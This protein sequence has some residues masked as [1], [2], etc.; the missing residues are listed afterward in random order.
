MVSSSAFGKTQRCK[1]HSLC[2]E[3]SLIHLGRQ[4]LLMTN[5]KEIRKDHSPSKMRCQIS[6]EAKAPE[7]RGSNCEGGGHLLGKRHSTGEFW[8]GLKSLQGL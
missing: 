7:G 5:K 1:S 6:A 3:E 2:I 8:V 4:K